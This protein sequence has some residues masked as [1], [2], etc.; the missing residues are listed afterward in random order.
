MR[1]YTGEDL[2]QCYQCENIF[3][4]NTNFKIHLRT[5]ILEILYQFN[6]CRKG[7]SQNSN[8]KKKKHLRT[9]SE[10]KPYQY[11]QYIYK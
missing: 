1:T 11:R 7:F 8:F 6:Q 5:H 10:E 2:Y 9:L 4:D 3:L